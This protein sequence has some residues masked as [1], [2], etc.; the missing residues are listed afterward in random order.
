MPNFYLHHP[1]HGQ[2]VVHSEQEA[3]YDRSNGWTDYFP[4]LVPTPSFLTLV[5]PATPLPENF[6]G[7]EQLVGAGMMTVESLLGLTAEDLQKVN[8]IGVATAR[9]ILDAQ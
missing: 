9:R 3:Q 6:P 7:R 1:L 5:A 2:R 8:G 4:A